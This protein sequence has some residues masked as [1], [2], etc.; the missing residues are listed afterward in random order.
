MKQN[1]TPILY[2]NGDSVVWGAEL[3]NKETQRFSGILSKELGMIDCNNSSAGVSNDYI[4]RQTMRD[5][6]HWLE[7]GE[8][9]SEESGWVTSKDIFVTIGWTSPT[10]FEWWNGTSYQQERLWKGYDKWGDDDKD[11]STED[12]FVLNQTQ[13]LPSY[14]RT[15]NHIL[16]LSSWL[17]LNGIGFNFYNTF[18]EYDLSVEQGIGKIDSFGRNEYQTCLDYTW[19]NLPKDFTENTMYNYLITEGGGFLPR[20]H[21]TKESHILW[22][23]YLKD[24][25]ATYVF[26]RSLR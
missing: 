9:W 17:D 13:D 12:E 25:R 5:V 8:C 26:K 21:P 10:R 16:A 20:K 22:A 19:K 2:S 4:Y 7:T 3:E 23:N 24:T 6:T 15:F 11:K 1:K 14:I 18:Y